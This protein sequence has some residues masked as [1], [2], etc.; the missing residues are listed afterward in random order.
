M[1]CQV[2]RLTKSLV[3]MSAFERFL[4]S[5]YSLVCCQTMRVA[6]TLLTKCTLERFLTT[7]CSYMIRQVVKPTETLAT[8]C[9]LERFLARVYFQ[10]NIQ[11]TFTTER[12]VTISAY[13]LISRFLC[14]MAHWLLM[15]MYIFPGVLTFVVLQALIFTET[16][17]TK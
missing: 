9:A 6:E 16:L 4:T 8:K 17:V 2:T 1:R 10:M 11:A 14:G 7:M 13:V 3:T 15:S 12:L 5:V